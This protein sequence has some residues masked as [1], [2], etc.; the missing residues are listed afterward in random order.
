M[1]YKLSG[2]SGGDGFVDG[3]LIF[4]F[5]GGDRGRQYGCT[6]LGSIR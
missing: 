4:D 5:Q 6:V 3:V 2:G 1:W